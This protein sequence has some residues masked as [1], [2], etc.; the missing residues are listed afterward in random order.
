MTATVHTT[1]TSVISVEEASSAP[2]VAGQGPYSFNVNNG[3]TSWFGGRVPP[4]TDNLVTSTSVVTL[5][6]V[7]ESSPVS[8]EVPEPTTGDTPTTSYTTTFLTTEV[9]L[10]R[11][12][13]L[14]ESMP[15]GVA[16]AKIFSGLGSSGWNVT[17]TT[18]KTV[19]ISQGGNRVAKSEFPKTG[20]DGETRLPLPGSTLTLPASSPSISVTKHKHARQL[21]AVIEATI[22]GVIVSWTNNYQG[23]SASTSGHSGPALPMTTPSIVSSGKLLQVISC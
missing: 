20:L 15:S 3:V 16:S 21:G 7:P 1:L 17:Y 6:P 23:S 18:F 5:V 4:S 12:E 13:T 22:D 8:G 2:F 9:S 14:T 10:I 11:T 19:K